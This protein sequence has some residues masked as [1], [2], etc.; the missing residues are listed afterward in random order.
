MSN[1]KDDKKFSWTGLALAGALGSSLVVSGAAFLDAVTAAQSSNAIADRALDTIVQ[2]RGKLGT[3][4]VLSEN[5]I[6]TIGRKYLDLLK[7]HPGIVAE[8]VKKPQ[9]EITPKD[10]HAYALEYIK[11]STKAGEL[12]LST[13]V[14]DD[15]VSRLILQ[16]VDT[17]N[18]TRSAQAVS[19]SLRGV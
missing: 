1:K 11:T 19:M 6:Y 10:I 15:D 8:S 18:Q 7:T 5:D 16:L 14:S 2:D 4:V 13:A 17:I 12:R 9:N 3:S